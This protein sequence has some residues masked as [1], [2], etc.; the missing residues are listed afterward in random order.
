MDYISFINTYSLGVVATV[1][2]DGNPSAALIGMAAMSSGQ[3]LLCAKGDGRTLRNIRDRSRVALVFSRDDIETIQIE[4]DAVIPGGDDLT[5][6]LAE[7]R[8]ANPN[9]GIFKPGSDLILVVVQPTWVRR[10]SIV[11]GEPVVSEHHIR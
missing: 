5:R 11:L 10:Y 6:F 7:W 1:A 8:L 2:P 9:S 3:I 4:G